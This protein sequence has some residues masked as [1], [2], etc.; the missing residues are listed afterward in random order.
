VRLLARGELTATGAM[1]PERAIDPD[2]MF[3]ELET[4]GCRFSVSVD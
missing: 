1:P 2:A 4:R 3:A